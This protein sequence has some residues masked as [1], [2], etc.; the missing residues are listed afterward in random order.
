MSLKGTWQET[1]GLKIADEG[2]SICFSLILFWEGGARTKEFCISGTLYLSI[3]GMHK[4]AMCETNIES[5]QTNNPNQT[6]RS[7]QVAHLDRDSPVPPG[8]KHSF[9]LYH[10]LL[11][12]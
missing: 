12:G 2:R 10:V 6:V 3:A 7:T 1:V 5:T 4:D 8:L 9:A 11:M